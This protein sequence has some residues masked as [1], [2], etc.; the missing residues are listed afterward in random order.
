MDRRRALAEDAPRCG[1]RA[2]TKAHTSSRPPAALSRLGSAQT[3]AVVEDDGLLEIDGEVKQ[4]LDDEEGPLDGADEGG[5]EGEVLGLVV[6]ELLGSR[7]YL[8]QRSAAAHLPQA[9]H[10]QGCSKPF[11][12]D[13]WL[14]EARRAKMSDCS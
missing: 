10:F 3:H 1:L 4:P 13:F 11:Y 7:A 6:K 12:A 8:A 14:R 2:P 9:V 5:R